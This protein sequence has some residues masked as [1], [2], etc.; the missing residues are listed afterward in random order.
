ML[1]LTRAKEDGRTNTKDRQYLR[2]IKDRNLAE[3]IGII[4]GDGNLYKHLRTENL[5]ITVN[6]RDKYYIYHIVN[7]IESV[8]KKRPSVAKRKGKQAVSINLYQNQISKRLGIPAGDKIRNNVSIPSWIIS[9]KKYIIRCLKGLFETDGCFQEDT[10][11]YAQ[12]IEFKNNCG[13]LLKDTYA[14][15]SRLGFHPQYG[16][17][18]I[19]LAKRDEVYRFKDLIE[20][21]HYIAL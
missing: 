1:Q 3:L 17:N 19:R 4:L 14:L 13:M 7:L 12:Y 15:V 9:N 5:R 11:N 6:S 18:Y 2:L 16:S 10:A 21:R 8:F 20:F